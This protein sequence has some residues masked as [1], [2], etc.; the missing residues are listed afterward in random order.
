MFLEY[1]VVTNQYDST[2]NQ[3]DSVKSKYFAIFFCSNSVN[4]EELTAAVRSL[5]IVCQLNKKAFKYLSPF[6][7]G[8]IVFPF[9]V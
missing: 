5:D 6:G 3:R 7:N 2:I 1:S 9:R 8:F 4:I